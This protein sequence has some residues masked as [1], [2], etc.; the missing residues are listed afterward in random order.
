V[1]A[2]A[3]EVGHGPPFGGP[4]EGTELEVLAQV[5][6][7]LERH[8]VAA[9]ELQVRDRSF[10]LRREGRASRVALAEELGELREAHA[11]ALGDRGRGAVGAEEALLVVGV[12][13]HQRGD[14]PGDAR[15]AG[16]RGVLC[17]RQLEARAQG[18]QPQRGGRRA[19]SEQKHCFLHTDPALYYGSVTVT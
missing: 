5:A 13:R 6:A 18:W 4:Q 16:E 12:V 8:P 15:V 11:P 14:A 2:V 9:R 17:L 3:V 7:V 1:E 19:Q 10:R